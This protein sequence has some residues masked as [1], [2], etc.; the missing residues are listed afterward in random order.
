MS[1]LE[2][3]ISKLREASEPLFPCAS[4][5]AYRIGRIT[6]GLEAEGQ[7][8]LALDRELEEFSVEETALQGCPCDVALR[9]S[10]V[11]SLQA[12]S[13]TPLFHSGGLWSLYAEPTG[14]RFS[15]L[16]P[17]LGMTPY[18]E[19]W[20]DSEFRSGRVLLSRRYFDTSAPVY[21]LEYPLDELLMIH[22]LSRGEG[23]EVHAVGISDGTGR[24]HLFL[25]HS[26][27]GKSTT[28]RLWLN[29]PGVKILSDD[30][31]ILRVRDGR[32]FMHGTPWHGDAGIASP[33]S[34]PLTAVYLL[35]HGKS[36]ER[37][38]LSPG[39]AA[40][41]LFARTFA[42]HHSEE[43][44]RFTLDFLDRVAREVPCFLFRFVPDQSAVEAICCAEA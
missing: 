44:I 42:T 16:S 4:R 13:S 8:R 1:A 27:A 29:R 12:P 30:R 24:G 26:G 7:L 11:D 19:A 41:E 40:A 33:D 37:L 32:I 28:A 38:P 10:W 43:G 22:R 6:F 5:L 2:Q 17:L 25:G 35:D 39:H 14:Y 15:F 23:V 36:N 3:Q 9:V 20:L 34:A 18:K 21:P 31:I